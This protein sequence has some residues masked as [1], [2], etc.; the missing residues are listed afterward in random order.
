MA[1][2]TLREQAMRDAPDFPWLSTEDVSTVELLLRELGVL[3]SLEKVESSS[4]AGEGNMNL[5]LRVRTT[6]RTV[7]VK[8]AR[9]W[10]EKYAHIA[11]PW[12]RIVFET[13]FYQRIAGIPQVAEC[14]PTVLAASREASILVLEDL[15]TS[16]DYG[17]LYQGALLH[18]ADA[19]RLARYLRALHDSTSDDPDP[20]FANREMRELNHTHI[21]RIPL[22]PDNGVALDPL[23]PGLADVAAALCEDTDLAR[24]MHTLGQH[25]LEDGRHLVHGDFFPGSWLHSPDGPRVIDPEFCYYGYREWDLGVCLAHLRLSSQDMALAE[26]FLHTYNE[27]AP[28]D[29]GIDAELIRDYAAAEIILR[30]LGVAQLPIPPSSGA[31]TGMVLAARRALLGGTLA[32]IWH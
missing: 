17:S 4:R 12:S 27:A 25:Y 1:A 14:M 6:E 2:L 15:G 24:R 10:V 20:G 7:I 26:H 11:A 30:L 16:G 18:D 19:E 29:S 8:Q 13:R 5:T 32:C 23:E 22:Q 31:R 28:R 3:G 21:F 9:P